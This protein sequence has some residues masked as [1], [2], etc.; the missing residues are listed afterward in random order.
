MVLVSL[1]VIIFFCFGF[2]CY[3]ERG[4]RFKTSP[5]KKSRAFL[6]RRRGGRA[7]L[8]EPADRYSEAK[9]NTDGTQTGNPQ[10]SQISQMTMN[11]SICGV[12]VFCG[13]VS[14]VAQGPNGALGERAL[15]TYQGFTSPAKFAR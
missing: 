9:M 7:R 3:D 13:R 8:S 4:D 14:S 12:C 10:I 11:N 1:V 6:P 15:P 5:A 2:H